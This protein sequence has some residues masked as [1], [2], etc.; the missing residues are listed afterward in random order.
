VRLFVAIEL[1]EA[2]RREVRR[3]VAGL[4]ERLPRAR[5]A[6]TD[7]MHLTLLFLGEVEPD[8]LAGLGAALRSACAGFAAFELRLAGGG[9]FPP[10]RPARV[11][12]IGVE[13]P[14]ELAAL[15]A[16]ITR[17]ATATVGFEPEERAFHPHVTVARCPSPWPRQV[18]EKLVAAFPGEVGPPFLAARALLLESKLSPRGARYR[19][20]EELPFAAARMSA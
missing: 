5:W 14:P 2:V 19:E 13:A 12:W 6:D 8:A 17:A 18:A 11:A 9:T 10:G 15:Q 16:G 4:R 20:V 7:A 1:P 3:R